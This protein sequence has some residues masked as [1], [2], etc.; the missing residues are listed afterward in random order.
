MSKISEQPTFVMPSEEEDAAILAAA[1]ADPDALPLTDKQLAA[2]VPL[3]SLCG[4]PPAAIKMI[5]NV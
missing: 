4:Q 1:N 3:C 2:M 5:L